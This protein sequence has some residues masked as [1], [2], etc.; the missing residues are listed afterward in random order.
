M[1]FQ[2]HAQIGTF[3]LPYGSLIHMISNTPNYA[4]IV[5]SPVSI[6]FQAITNQKRY[7]VDT[8]EKLN[9]PIQVYLMNLRDGTV[10]D[11]FDV[12]DTSL[13]F[14]THHINAWEESQDIVFDIVTMPWDKNAHFMDLDEVLH[15]T[16]SNDEAAKTV[17]KRITLNL[18]T[19]GVKVEDWPNKLGIPILTTMDYPVINPAFAG[20]KNQFVY[21]HASIDFWKQTLIKKDLKDSSKDKTWSRA[22]HYPGEMF[23]IPKSGLHYT[24]P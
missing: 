7:P 3:A 23:F 15:H 19:Q 22:S 14:A 8:A 4:V 24:F 13:A 16:E 10:M 12:K 20:I 1:W 18:V 9:D 6:D 21:G 2:D 11:G 5:V 17:V